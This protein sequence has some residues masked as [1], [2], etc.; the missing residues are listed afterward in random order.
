MPSWILKKKRGSH[1]VISKS[2]YFCWENDKAS[3]VHKTTYFKSYQY[4]CF[5]DINVNIV[6]WSFLTFTE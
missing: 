4:F 1:L 3:Y 6:S 5:I 2:I